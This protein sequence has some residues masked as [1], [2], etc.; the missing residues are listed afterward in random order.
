[1]TPA[2]EP[3]PGPA[4]AEPPQSEPSQP[5]HPVAGAGSWALPLGYSAVL[6]AGAVALLVRDPHVPGSWGVCPSVLLGFACPGCGGLR[7]TSELL[8]GDLAAAWAYNPLVVV[9]VPLVLLLL[10]RWFLD[11]RRGRE[12]WSPPTAAVTVVAVL[13]VLFGIA[14]NVPALSPFLGPLAIP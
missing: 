14:R 9:G 6:A 13:V 5:T 7:G 1:M 10:G 11:A 4:A 2:S 12:P 8:R 3:P